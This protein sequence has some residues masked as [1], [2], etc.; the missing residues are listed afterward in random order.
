LL[1]FLESRHIH[2]VPRRPSR[3]ERIFEALT[4]IDERWLTRKRLKAIL[5]GGLSMLGLWAMYDLTRWLLASSSPA[6]EYLVRVLL[7]QITHA[8]VTSTT[9]LAWL[10]GTKALKAGCGL[11]LLVGVGLWLARREALALRLLFFVLLL[12]LTVVNL[13]EFYFEQF[14]TIVPAML[15]LILL[16]FLI[17]Y[18]RRFL[19][20]APGQERKV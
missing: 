8:R 18:R 16:L 10:T 9:G 13:L 12:F 5:I 11:A 17:H 1:Q 3:F 19:R 14:S 15:Q 7:D 6:P 20:E 4:G 2:L